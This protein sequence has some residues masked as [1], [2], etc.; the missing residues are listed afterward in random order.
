MYDEALCT[1][2]FL[3]ELQRVVPDSTIQGLLSGHG[4]DTEGELALL[5]PA[6]R[7][8]VELMRISKIDARVSGMLYKATFDDQYRK[9][10]E[11]S[12]L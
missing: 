1:E 9:L 2:S 6:D 10:K 3:S 7:F 8:L 11:V 4:T 5:H 12:P